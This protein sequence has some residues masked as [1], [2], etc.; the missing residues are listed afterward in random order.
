MFLMLMV[1]YQLNMIQRQCILQSINTIIHLVNQLL[2]YIV[3]RSYL[4]YVIFLMRM[5]V[6]HLMF[7]LFGDW[8]QIFNISTTMSL[9]MLSQIQMNHYNQ[10]YNQFMIIFLIHYS[11][12]NQLIMMYL[13]MS[14]QLMYLVSIVQFNLCLYH[15]NI[16]LLNLLVMHHYNFM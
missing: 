1:N 4:A 6:Q 9:V 16:M 3:Y 12:G 15:L 2:V 10:Y 5:V 8:Q 7:K 13:I 14:Y 11:I